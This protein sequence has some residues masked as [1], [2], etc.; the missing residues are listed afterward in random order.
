MAVF[1]STSNIVVSRQRV[2]LRLAQGCILCSMVIPPTLGSLSGDT[3]IYIW[4]MPAPIEYLFYTCA[5]FLL[6]SN[7]INKTQKVAMP[8]LA[9]LGVPAFFWM[10]VF[11][12]S[13]GN[14]L[15]WIAI[16]CFAFAGLIVG[17]IWAIQIDNWNL[18]AFVRNL[19][20]ASFIMFMASLI[21]EFLGIISS[22]KGI[23]SD[24]ETYASIW[25]G[26]GTLIGFLPTFYVSIKFVQSRVVRAMTRIIVL[27]VPF[28]GFAMA[29]IMVNRGT[30]V[31]VFLSSA[32]L[33]RIVSLNRKKAIF[34]LLSVVAISLVVVAVVT[35]KHFKIL[36]SIEQTN[37]AAKIQGKDI[38]YDPRFEEVVTILELLE[39]NE[40]TGLG[41][42]SRYPV[43]FLASVKGAEEG[44]AFAPHLGT[45]AFLQKGGYPIYICFVVV[46]FVFA[47]YRF[48]GPVPRDDVS[49]AFWSQV[50]LYLTLSTC[51]TGGW[52][53]LSTFFYGAFFTKALQYSPNQSGQLRA[54]IP[55][56]L[57]K[58]VN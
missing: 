3:K 32:C 34:I 40:F 8:V 51:T 10:I 30:M 48:L 54:G 13:S 53:F 49:L 24:L 12:I 17:S 57:N 36:D 11:G 41:F 58:D 43:T 16:D 9:L 37:L 52:S 42:G 22:E 14:Q 38:L 15:K 5:S 18:I 6:L 4:G 26:I 1:G 39:N 31:A 35:I 50:L 20:L 33:M 28:V 44:L 56:S 46:P 25:T 2:G 21:G 7:W 29:F 47:A 45:F 27:C 55:N 23:G 19:C